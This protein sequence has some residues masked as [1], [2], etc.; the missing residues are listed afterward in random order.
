MACPPPGGGGYWEEHIFPQHQTKKPQRKVNN[1]QKFLFSSHDITIKW[2]NL[3]QKIYQ[4]MNVEY[5]YKH[6][7]GSNADLLDSRRR[8][9]CSEVPDELISS[10]CTS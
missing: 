9:C 10:S 2:F 5:Y 7:M 3:R 6:T 8:T 4:V 1:W